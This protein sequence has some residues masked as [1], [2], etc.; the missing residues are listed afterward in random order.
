[1]A[2]ARKEIR[3]IGWSLSGQQDNCTESER[4]DRP[5]YEVTARDIE[6]VR[7][8]KLYDLELVTAR[9][10][11]PCVTAFEQLRDTRERSED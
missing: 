7:A 9:L 3:H 8:H 4:T 11:P 2:A 1:M 10:T 6:S 5:R